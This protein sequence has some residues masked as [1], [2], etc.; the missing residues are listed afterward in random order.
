VTS[1]SM[2]S[3]SLG[4]P[5]TMNDALI[6]GFTSTVSTTLL[7]VFCKPAVSPNMPDLTPTDSCS[8]KL[9]KFS[10][11][12]VLLQA[13]TP[14][15]IS[16]GSIFMLMGR[17]SVHPLVVWILRGKTPPVIFLFPFS[18]LNCFS[19]ANILSKLQALSAA[20]SDM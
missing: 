5:A 9:A 15:L 8:L 13:S 7:A 1:A 19:P 14:S 2:S 18:L 11:S 16:S 6:K 4:R 20:S 12:F 3:S 17:P 10:C